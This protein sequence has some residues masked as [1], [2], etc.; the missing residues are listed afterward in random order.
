MAYAD[1]RHCDVCGAKAFYDANLSYDE[2]E[3]PETGLFNLGAWLC[4]CIAC[5]KTHELKIIKKD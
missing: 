3:Y 2:E 5:A 1:Y 4:L